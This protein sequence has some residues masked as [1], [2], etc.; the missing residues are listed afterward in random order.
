[1]KHIRLEVGQIKHLSLKAGHLGLE[2]EPA[3]YH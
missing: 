1:M 3:N 2:F